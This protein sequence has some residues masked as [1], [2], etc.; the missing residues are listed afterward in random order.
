[1]AKY[2]SYRI[3][4]DKSDRIMIQFSIK[5]SK[6]E[7]IDVEPEILYYENG[8]L[9]ESAYKKAIEIE[10]ASIFEE[11]LKN[12]VNTQELS[13]SK[14]QLPDDVEVEK[15]NKS[16]L[17]K[18][19]N[20]I[21]WATVALG[22]AAIVISAAKDIKTNDTGKAIPNKPDKSTE[23]KTDDTKSKTEIE[24]KV[25][26]EINKDGIN[27]TITYEEA[28]KNMES[29]YKD[30]EK[31]LKDNDSNAKIDFESVEAFYTL[32]NLENIAPEA[33][34]KMQEEERLPKD[35]VSFVNACTPVMDIVG[36]E[37][38]AYMYGN[39]KSAIINDKNK[40]EVVERNVDKVVD[41]RKYVVDSDNNDFI[42]KLYAMVE[43]TRKYNKEDNTDET[44]KQAQE[45][46][47]NIYKY[48]RNENGS[49]LGTHNDTNV[50]IRKV[51]DLVF[52]N[53]I[54]Q[55][56]GHTANN[57]KDA[58]ITQ[59]Q[60][61]AITGK[62]IDPATG[63]KINRT[64][65]NNWEDAIRMFEKVCDRQEKIGGLTSE[66]IKKILEEYNNQEE[67]SKTKTK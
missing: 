3:F 11:K 21:A 13:V 59:K 50:G 2:Q 12:A 23:G 45:M 62:D 49:T 31:T 6:G 4:K 17:E 27:E 1:M 42:N 22:V 67:T 33:I 35:A 14:K 38:T 30:I 63:E 32:M 58:Y 18:H 5:N 10:K 57:G 44:K 60:I 51:G 29:M 15:V 37:I 36:H 28:I 19:I 8:L 61:D 16:W 66:E 54:L 47:E 7:L 43:E 24:K 46:Y 53:S 56:L 39:D 25:D 20:K 40:V 65:I 41:I 48:M 26:E 55:G 64:E 34:E 9:N 52:V